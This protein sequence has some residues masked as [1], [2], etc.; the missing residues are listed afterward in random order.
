LIRIIPHGFRRTFRPAA[1]RR[2]PISPARRRARWRRVLAA[3]LSFPLGFLIGLPLAP[4]AGAQPEAPAEVP[5]AIP[6]AAPKALRFRVE[7]EAPRPL[8]AMLESGLD[9]VRWQKDERMTPDLL[10]RLVVEARAETERAAAAEGWFSA[11]VDTAIERQ[12]EVSVVRLV[13]D[14]GPRTT[15][16]A[17]DLQFRGAVADGAERNER[18]IA[19]VR[20]EWR[21]RSGDPFRQLDWE[22]AKRGA[23]TELAR[24]LYAAAS[25][26][27]SEARVDPESRTA[28]L[29]VELDS[30]PPFRFGSVQVSGT[31]RYSARIVENL[32]GIRPGDEYD[33]TRLAVFQRR[34]LETGYFATAQI[35][36][37]RD[38][39]NAD[40][41]PV[42]VT[43]AEARSQRV[44]T[45]INF[46]TDTRLGAQLNYTNQDLA[47]S[48]LRL[49]S[50][51]KVDEKTQ[52]VE[53]AVDTPPR[54][55]GVW[56]T[57]QARYEATDI[58][59]QRTDGTMVGVSYNWGVERTPSQVSLSGHHERQVV[60]GSTTERND[61]LF[62]GFRQ[63]YRFTDDP[64][65]P[66]RGVLGSVQLG[67]S[68]PHM[69]T[70]EFVRATAKVNILVPFGRTF[71]L[72]A[73]AEGG[74]VFADSR[75]GIPTTFLFR[76]GGDQTIRGYSFQSIGV[77]QGAAIVGGRYMAVGSVEATYWFAGDWGAAAFVDAG[78]AFDDRNAFD[79]AIGY[80][81]G[82]RWRSPIGPF[83]ADVAYGQR[84]GSLRMHFSVG[85]SF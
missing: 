26:V 29:R 72:S 68:L 35:S 53:A 32:Y 40:A 82:V 19:A 51:L 8:K 34:L 15:V 48:A 33:A 80:G 85:F 41:A 5:A 16:A 64:L 27:A 69:A 20:R 61:A 12:E 44:D 11:K 6:A 1:V 23:V 49:R 58:Q 24:E 71:D 65:L 57:V 7:I 59:N 62:L 77:P 75:S 52:T 78:D 73:R 14:P 4:A 21:L 70:Q 28:T 9:L 38:P 79:V 46:S 42:A 36:V 13:V 39:A 50:L 45:G 84:A 81:V 55:G 18:R 76:T 37:D 67:S 83:R 22:A 74:Y 60:I 66:R 17:I 47:D 30:G 43:V 10:E 2:E 54:T 3:G 63:V 25:I 56:N 31:R